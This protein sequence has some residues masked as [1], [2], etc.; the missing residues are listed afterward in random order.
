MASRAILRRLLP[1]VVWAGVIFGLSSI[2][3][4][5]SGLRLIWDVVLRKI[6]HAVE[7]GIL[8]I[9]L[10]RAFAPQ[11]RRS[12]TIAFILA[13]LYAASDEWHQTFVANRTG[14]WVDVLIDALGVLLGLVVYGRV[15]G[16]RKED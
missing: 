5:E 16:K 14:S 10:V 9:L 15:R 3:S 1:P 11:T 7:F 13:T 6:A 8:G 4:L 12:L 2:P